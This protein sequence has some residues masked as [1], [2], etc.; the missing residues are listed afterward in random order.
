VAKPRA[1]VLH[2]DRVFARRGERAPDVQEETSARTIL[3]ASRGEVAWFCPVRVIEM[4]WPD[5]AV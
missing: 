2:L 3:D 4:T 1:G 5:L